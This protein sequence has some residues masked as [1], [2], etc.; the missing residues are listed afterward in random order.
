MSTLKSIYDE[1]CIA[2]KAYSKECGNVIEESCEILISLL[3]ELHH[4]YEFPKVVK[5]ENMY[6][7]NLRYIC[8]VG[9]RYCGMFVNMIRIYNDNTL[10]ASERIKLTYASYEDEEDFDY[11]QC[12]P[13]DMYFGEKADERIPEISIKYD[14]DNFYNLVTSLRPFFLTTKLEEDYNNALKRIIAKEKEL[15]RLEDDIS[16]INE[17]L[18]FYLGDI[19]VRNCAFDKTKKKHFLM[20]PENISIRYRGKF[21]NCLTKDRYAISLGYIKYSTHLCEEG[22][23]QDPYTVGN[24]FDRYIQKDMQLMHECSLNSYCNSHI[25][26]RNA[27]EDL[28][29][30]CG[31]D[32]EKLNSDNYVNE[33]QVDYVKTNFC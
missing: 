33:S 29:F 17:K 32:L 30:L 20:L 4:V 5:E 7:I 18:E 3:K 1:F 23:N 19:F 2:N 13:D 31:E 21:H 15:Q 8:R 24:D 25:E 12:F 14:W 9:I 28:M 22:Y 26:L 10:K 11:A 6:E 16:I 27:L